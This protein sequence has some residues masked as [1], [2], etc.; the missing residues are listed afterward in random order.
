MPLE[1]LIES[2]DVLN[3]GGQ[4]NPMALGWFGHLYEHIWCNTSATDSV[5]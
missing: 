1:K 5:F 4:T 2:V 3:E